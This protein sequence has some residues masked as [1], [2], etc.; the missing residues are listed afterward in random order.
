[1]FRLFEDLAEEDGRKCHQNCL[2]LMKKAGFWKRLRQGQWRQTSKKSEVDAKVYMNLP[3]T[4]K[5][6]DCT[7]GV[8]KIEDCWLVIHW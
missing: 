6:A 2:K 8:M 3:T 4:R 7:D 5:I 1:M